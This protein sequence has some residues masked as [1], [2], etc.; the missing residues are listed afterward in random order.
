MRK[1]GGRDSVRNRGLPLCDLRIGKKGERGAVAP[2]PCLPSGKRSYLLRTFLKR[3]AEALARANWPKPGSMEA[4]SELMIWS[5][6]LFFMMF[7]FTW[8]GGAS[9][10]LVIPLAAAVSLYCV[11]L[12]S[13]FFCCAFILS[14]A[15][16]QCHAT[17]V[18]SF[19]KSSAN[20]EEKVMFAENW[21]MHLIVHILCVSC[22]L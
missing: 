2:A 9:F 7:P 15:N 4:R 18:T 19:V 12:F 16:H 10:L 3:S 21:R 20:L 17:I 8:L 6:V 11:C 22:W 5:K 1:A 14:Q 13:S